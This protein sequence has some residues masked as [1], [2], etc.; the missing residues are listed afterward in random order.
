MR[1]FTKGIRRLVRIPSRDPAIDEAEWIV[2]CNTE[3]VFV[4]RLGAKKSEGRR[5]T[6]R[7]VIGEALLFAVK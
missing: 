5:I 3:G 1:E 7:R 2:A 4:R 6:W